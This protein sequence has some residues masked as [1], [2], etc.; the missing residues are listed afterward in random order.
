[1]CGGADKSCQLLWIQR[2]ELIT[3]TIM[4]ANLHTD[5]YICLH[6]YIVVVMWACF[7]DV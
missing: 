7:L 1:M 3:T 2:V 4:Q 5:T 6:R